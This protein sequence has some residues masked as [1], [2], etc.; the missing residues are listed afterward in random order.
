MGARGRRGGSSRRG[1]CGRGGGGRRRRIEES[2]TKKEG[3]EDARDTRDRVS[4]RLW[5]SSVFLVHLLG[6]VSI[7]VSLH[8]LLVVVGYI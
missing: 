7:C 2:K 4:K 6:C 1:R 3:D 5:S 8:L